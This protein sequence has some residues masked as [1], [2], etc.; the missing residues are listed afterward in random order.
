VAKRNIGIIRLGRLLRPWPR[1]SIHPSSGEQLI[2]E[3]I[4]ARVGSATGTATAAG[5]SF[6]GSIG[7]ADAGAVAQGQ[8]VPIGFFAS[9]GSATAQAIAIG[10]SVTGIGTGAAVSFALAV[11][12][13]IEARTGS[14]TAHAL[15]AGGSLADA[16]VGT[17]V[18]V[19]FALGG[20]SGGSVVQ[21]GA[22]LATGHG[23]AIG[24]SLLVAAGGF[25]NLLAFWIGGAGKGLTEATIPISSMSVGPIAANNLAPSGFTNPAGEIFSNVNWGRSGNEAKYFQPTINNFACSSIESYRDFEVTWWS[26]LMNLFVRVGDNGTGFRVNINEELD[27]AVVTVHQNIINNTNLN[28]NFTGFWEPL[29]PLPGEYNLAAVSGYS[30]ADASGRS[31]VFGV[32]GFDVYLRM[33][34]PTNPTGVDVFRTKQWI[35]LKSGKIHVHVWNGGYGM[36]DLTITP[37]PAPTLFSDLNNNI[38]DPRDWGAKAVATTGTINAS[39]NQLTVADASNL[40]I[41]DKIIVEIGTEAGAG[42]RGTVGVGGQWPA[43]TYAN[44]AARDA[45]L[46]QAHGTWSW[47]QSNGTTKWFDTND[48]MWKRSHWAPGDYYHAMAVPKA[49]RAIIINK[50]G[51]VLTL[52]AT[53]SATATNAGVYFNNSDALRFVW[54]EIYGDTALWSNKSYIFNMPAGQFAVNGYQFL[55]NNRQDWE[56]RGQGKDVTKIFSPK[57]A[58]EVQIQPVSCSNLTFHDFE[59]AGNAGDNYYN[60]GNYGADEEMPEIGDI[61]GGFGGSAIVFSKGVAFGGCVDTTAYNIRVRNVFDKA[62]GGDFCTGLDVHDCE[63]ILVNG[64]RRYIQWMIAAS[65]STDCTFTNCSVTSPTLVGGFEGFRSTT[66][67][68]INCSGT[69]TYSSMNSTGDFLF[70]DC[71]ITMTGNCELTYTTPFGETVTPTNAR[72]NPIININS[73]IQPPSGNMLLGGVIKN[74]T[75]VVEDYPNSFGDTF[76]AFVIINGQNPNVSIIGDPPWTT[77]P[78]SAPLTGGYFQ[79]VDAN[80]EGWPAV[81]PA[82]QGALVLDSDGAENILVDGIRVVGLGNPASFGAGN[83]RCISP[84]GIVQ[85]CVYEDHSVFGYPGPEPGIVLGAGAT[86]NNNLTTE[87]WEAL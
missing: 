58:K 84:G 67:K 54:Q 66:V 65:D 51:N 21:T 11:G 28:N 31:Y 3:G 38:L 76:R 50:V 53:A 42:L 60:A 86:Q 62:L 20:G 29:A 83:I 4:F 6:S 80:A 69:N 64:W 22:G 85:N 57:G 9:V 12:R 7:T 45:D 41:G 56:F 71:T 72:E 63:C 33:K 10:S 15:A 5:Q 24:N 37:L 46:T 61:G 13:T 73:N 23:L 32:R 19:A 26:R 68:F 82:G 79:S 52:D 77:R 78:T 81:H 25:E 59:L 18:A 43:L 36:H 74:Q 2:L 87:E 27:T 39:S 34:T 40:A 44:D 1:L 35:W 55:G 30:N 17:A 70:E 49:L 14:A 48:S 16:G 47:A 8:G 75:I